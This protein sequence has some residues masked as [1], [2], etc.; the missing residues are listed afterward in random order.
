MCV[1]SCPGGCQTK[2]DHPSRTRRSGDIGDKPRPCHRSKTRKPL[3]I[4]SCHRCHRCHWSNTPPGGG[5]PATL[6][7]D[8]LAYIKTAKLFVIPPLSSLQ[9]EMSSICPLIRVD[10]CPFVVVPFLTDFRPGFLA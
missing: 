9:A 2:A 7:I 10:S 1:D 3:E 4:W 5:T 8:Q 6:W